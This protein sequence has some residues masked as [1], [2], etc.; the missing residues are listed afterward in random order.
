MTVGYLIFDYLEYEVKQH[1]ILFLKKE[2]YMQ[3]CQ[4]TNYVKI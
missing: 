2:D 3:G 1:R 4:H